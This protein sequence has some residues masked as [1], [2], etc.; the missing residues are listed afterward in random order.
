MPSTHDEHPIQQLATD[1]A[2]PSLG[3][4]VRAWRPHRRPQ[5]SDALGGQ[6]G[7]EG[8]GEVGVAIADQERELVDAAGQTDQ[9]V[10]G[11]LGD[12]GAVGVDGDTGQV[13]AGCPVR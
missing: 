10:A 7:I 2:D 5:D 1:R 12:P 13:D 8:G 3:H 9:Q 6:D 11:L 4:R